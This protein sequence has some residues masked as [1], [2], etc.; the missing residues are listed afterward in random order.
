MCI[1]VTYTAMVM[2]VFI[3]HVLLKQTYALYWLV[4]FLL[5]Y[6]KVSRLINV[7]Q[8]YQSFKTFKVYLLH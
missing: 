8:S 1:G 6:H 5:S 2:K 3:H 4:I 7:Y